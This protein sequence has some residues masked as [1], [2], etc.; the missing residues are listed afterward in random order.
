[1]RLV[2]VR[3][4]LTFSWKR[5]RDAEQEDDRKCGLEHVCMM[6]LNPTPGPV[7][8]VC[9]LSTNQI[10]PMIFAVLFRSPLSNQMDLLD[11]LFIQSCEP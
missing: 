2:A 8:M 5:L 10:R 1:V 9:P 11:A 4:E 3:P 6:P 7:A